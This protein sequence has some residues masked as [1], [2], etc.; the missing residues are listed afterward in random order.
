MANETNPPVSMA[1]RRTWLIVVAAAVG[2]LVLLILPH[3]QTAGVKLEPYDRII[4]ENAIRDTWAKILV[5]GFFLLAAYFTWRYVEAVGQ[6]VIAAERTVAA[7]ERNAMIVQET[8][9]TER[10]VRSMELLGDEKLEV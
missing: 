5:G 3:L 7:A 8:Q 10:F 4:A 6:T 9:I 1:F 2:L